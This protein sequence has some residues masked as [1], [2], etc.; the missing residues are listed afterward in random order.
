[1]TSSKDWLAWHAPYA[2][3]HS[4]L[5]RRLRLVQEHIAAWLQERPCETL[6][7]VSVC[8]GQGHDLLGVLAERTDARRVHATLVEYDRRNVEIGRAGVQAAGLAEVHVVQADAGKRASYLGLVPADLVL[9]VGVFGNIS[10]ADVHR[11][12]EALPELCA[13][14]ATVI[15]T[16]T[17]RPPDLTV[18]I[19]G[20]LAQTGFVEQAF[21]SPEDAL[22][23][24]AVHR[25]VGAPRTLKVPGELFTFIA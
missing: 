7:V 6:N 5:S 19:R 16:R 17:R 11:T 21:H 23:S 18:Q 14:G 3:E 1:V 15:W 12:I 10:D 20:W 13:P 24:V 2:D 9:L 4:A 22:F 25:F 8:A